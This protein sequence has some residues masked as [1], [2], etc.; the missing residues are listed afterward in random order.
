MPTISVR[1]TDEELKRYQKYG[2]LS[3][4]IR[5]A[6]E[7]YEKAQKK[8][9]ALRKLDELQRKHPVHISTEEIVRIVRE[10]RNH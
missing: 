7:L 9:E 1:V 2:P 3:K 4:T 5:E 8:R 10:G 6:M